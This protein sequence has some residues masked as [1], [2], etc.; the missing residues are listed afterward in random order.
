MK[1]KGDDQDENVEEAGPDVVGE[2]EKLSISDIKREN[3][4]AEK[5]NKLGNN[6][7]HE[8]EFDFIVLGLRD[9][10]YEISPSLFRKAV[11]SVEKYIYFNIDFNGLIE[12][13]PP[14]I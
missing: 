7:G 3:D 6:D 8:R 9:F 1:I 2:R 13:E 10:E 14:I 11:S 4:D 12:F 5:S